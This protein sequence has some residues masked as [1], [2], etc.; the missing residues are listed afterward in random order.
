M[1]YV[2]MFVLS[3]LF[4][5]LA[6]CTPAS[7]EPAEASPV[8]T[9]AALATAVSPQPSAAAPKATEAPYPAA[10]SANDAYPGGAP[11]T[12]AYDPYPGESAA[13]APVA[14]AAYPAEDGSPQR[15]PMVG[16]PDSLAGI[17]LAASDDLAERLA[18]DVGDVSAIATE[19]ME[20]SDGSWGCP[21]PKMSYIQVI[22]PGY[23]L[24]LAVDGEQYEYHTDM[25]GNF[26][27]CGENGQPV[28]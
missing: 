13:A 12:A 8:V 25:N 14:D 7:E 23:L 11:S 3:I 24:T 9:K 16:I 6:A 20:W 19:E 26:V 15:M 17:V 22:T 21:D 28:P 10:G 1:K 2:M 5:S 27:L 4:V 18:V